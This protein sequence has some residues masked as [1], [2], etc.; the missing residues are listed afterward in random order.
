MAWLPKPLVTL[1]TYSRIVL[2]LRLLTSKNIFTK[3]FPYFF[4]LML[5]AQSRK[6]PSS[7]TLAISPSYSLLHL[8][9]HLHVY[10]LSPCLLQGGRP[11][12]VKLHALLR[13]RKKVETSKLWCMGM[14]ERL[15]VCSYLEFFWMGI[16]TCQIG[17]TL[18]EMWVSCHL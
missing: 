4:L 8:H 14:K 2:L 15:R 10:S 16:P 12:C 3:N 1:N 13:G 5:T 17:I 11:W 9:Q 18:A 6:I 7:Y